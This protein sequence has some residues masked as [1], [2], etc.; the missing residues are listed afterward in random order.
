MSQTQ[1]PNDAAN[2]AVSLKAP[3]GPM[4]AGSYAYVQNQPS[5][6]IDLV[7]LLGFF[8]KIKFEIIL[9]AV[10]G[11]VTGAIIAFKVMP[12][13]Y[14][15]QISLVLD[16]NEI[17]AV[18]PKK[19][20]ESYN[21]ALNRSDNARL[22]WRSVFN[23]S[24][25]LA[26]ILKEVNLSDEVLASNQALADKP[27]KSPL[28]LRESASPSDFILDVQLPVEGLT[29]RSG[30]LFASAIQM[31]FNTTSGAA[32]VDK[33]APAQPTNAIAPGG[34]PVQL[35]GREES[36]GVREQLIKARQE[37]LKIEYL[38]S[39]LGRGLTDFN[40]FVSSGDSDLKSLQVSIP[41]G[42]ESTA[43]ALMPIASYEAIG[44]Q[45]Q[46]ERIQRMTSVL[47]AEGRMKAEDANDTVT[48]AFQVRDDIFQLL[49]A[50]RSEANR[51]GG[52]AMQRRSAL[53]GEIRSG[54]SMPVLPILVPSSASG[55]T[56]SLEEPE[57][58]RKIALVLGAFL[59]AFLGFASGGIR[60]FLKKN[61]QRLREVLA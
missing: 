46:F 50:A 48:R 15:T 41:A 56:L 13:T 31:A 14:R 2:S 23:Q 51:V 35:A 1:P 43:Q 39:K 21:N 5:D 28:R 44:V 55:A 6:E 32:D 19:L 36:N 29:Q 8:W 26:R 3:A 38:C 25:E 37:L 7:E 49:P 16:K 45:G 27:E 10:L 57:S 52:L 33:D 22:V 18:E 58:K 34:A 9:G 47:L 17:G 61:G 4:A 59:G 40:A 12:V 54:M 42:A 20:V 60:I 30:E 24:P 11:I 53:R